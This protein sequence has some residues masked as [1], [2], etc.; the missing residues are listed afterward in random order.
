MT[1]IDDR[2]GFRLDKSISLGHIFTTV[3]MLLT[4]VWWAAGVEKRFAVHDTQI[5][6]INQMMRR[7]DEDRA[8]ARAEILQQLLSMN[9]KLDRSN[10]KLDRFIQSQIRTR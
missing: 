6:E 7:Q 4:V 1:F 3:S 10:D 2:R 9:D 5:V 8:R